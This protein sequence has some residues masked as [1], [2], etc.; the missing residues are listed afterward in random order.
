MTAR[1]GSLIRV[2][3]N[4]VLTDYISVQT[5]T[6]VA[7]MLSFKK[8]LIEDIDLDCRFLSHGLRISVKDMLT[9]E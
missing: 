1:K 2:T 6:R 7:L 3:L 8:W 5:V 9:V 4:N